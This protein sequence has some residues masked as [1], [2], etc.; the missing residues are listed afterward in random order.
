VDFFNDKMQK[1][2]EAIKIRLSSHRTEPLQLD[3]AFTAGSP[4]DGLRPPTEDEV[5]RLISTMPNKIVTCRLHTDFRHQV[6]RR[7]LCTLNNSTG[8]TIFQ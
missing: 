8:E 1:A 3:T 6:V 2:K 5:R 4:L 7:R